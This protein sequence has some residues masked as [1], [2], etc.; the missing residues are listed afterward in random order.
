MIKNRNELKKIL[1]FSK[2]ERWHSMKI[3]ITGGTGFVGATHL[4]FH[5]GWDEVTILTRSSKKTERGPRQEFPI[6]RGIRQRRAPGRKPLRTTT[7]SSILQVPRSLPSGLRNIRRLLRESRVSTTRN[8]VEGDT[9]R[10]LQ[11]DHSVQHLC[12]RLLWFLRR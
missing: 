11:K 8:I 5:P 4:P 2:A 1:R 10:S 9:I 7:P 12:R 3:L 6:S